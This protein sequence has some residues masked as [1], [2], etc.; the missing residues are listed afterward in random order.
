MPVFET[1][2]SRVATAARA[3]TPDV[4]TYDELPPL[5]RKQ[6]SKIFT[7][8]IG[9][10]WREPRGF[11][12]GADVAPNNANGVWEKIAQVMDR[13]VGSFSLPSRSPCAY[14]YCVTYLQ[15][16]TDLNGILGLIEM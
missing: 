16:S 8:C 15:K 11:V 3:D 6:L 12:P 2:A 9:P 7:E 13:E 1:Y 14:E 4:Y 5:L 10:G